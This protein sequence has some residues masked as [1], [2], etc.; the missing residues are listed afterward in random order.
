MPDTDWWG[1]VMRQLSA[2]PY[3]VV[4]ATGP[5]DPRAGV[6]LLVGAVGH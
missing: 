2:E 1:Q 4:W 6:G 3:P 5:R